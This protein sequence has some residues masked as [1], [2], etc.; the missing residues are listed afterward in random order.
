MQEPWKDAVIQQWCRLLLE[1]YRHW[2]RRDL[3]AG[4]GTPEEQARALFEAPFVVVSHGL[5]DDPV[6]N[7]GN[8]VALNLWEMTWDQ[9]TRTPSRLTAEPPDQAARARML[10]Q[11][12][13]RGFIDNYRG[14]RISGKGRRF[15]VNR[16]LVWK[17]VDPAGRRRGQAATFN[18]WTFVGDP[19]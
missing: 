13:E 5:E 10:A 2:T 7:F 19:S 15:L 12:E 11:A 14:V 1:S 8:R 16:A 17:V 18:S 9:F 6:L 4:V 3:I